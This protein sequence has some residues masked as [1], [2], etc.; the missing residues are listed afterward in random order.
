MNDHGI[1][2][3]EKR[4]S[5]DMFFRDKDVLFPLERTGDRLKNLAL[6][7]KVLSRFNKLTIDA[8][9]FVY[10]TFVLTHR[11]RAVEVCHSCISDATSF[12]V[13]K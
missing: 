6:Q 13:Y 9:L 8:R 7:T 4:S 5:N 10:A 3:R 12:I 1:L 2:D 11:A